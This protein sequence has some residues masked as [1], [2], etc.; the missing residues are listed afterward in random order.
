MRGGRATDDDCDTK[1]PI[2]FLGRR[3]KELLALAGRACKLQPPRPVTGPGLCTVHAPGAATCLGL[4]L[5]RSRHPLEKHESAAGKENAKLPSWPHGP[6]RLGHLFSPPI[7]PRAARDVPC[8]LARVFFGLSPQNRIRGRAVRSRCG[9]RR[10]RPPPPSSPASWRGHLT[11]SGFPRPHPLSKGLPSVPHQLLPTPSPFPFLWCLSNARRRPE[12]PRRR[13]PR[14][15]RPPFGHGDGEGGGRS[16][17]FVGHR[18]P[19]RRTRCRA[20]RRRRLN[21]AGHYARSSFVGV[22]GASSSAP[23]P[24][25]R[26]SSAEKTMAPPAAAAASDAEADVDLAPSLMM[27]ANHFLVVVADDN[28]F[29][30]DVR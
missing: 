10:R 25:A 29:R 30:N 17:S 14:D 27:C 12:R 19:Q 18:R 6:D 26:S 11:G 13:R 23:S 15:Q 20:E 16:S 22:A 1:F 28:L 7:T 21:G 2:F 9:E 4:A 8:A 3:Q 5:L 24:L